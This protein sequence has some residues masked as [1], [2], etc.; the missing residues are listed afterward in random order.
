MFYYLKDVGRGWRV[1]ALD[2]QVEVDFIRQGQRGITNLRSYWISGST[3]GP[4]GSLIDFSSYING[5][6][7]RISAFY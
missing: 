2:N 1:A 6:T 5:D 7:G 4:E 3:N